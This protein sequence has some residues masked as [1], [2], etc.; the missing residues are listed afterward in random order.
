MSTA[1][2]EVQSSLSNL[3]DDCSL[4]E[5]GEEESEAREH[6]E[7]VT[8]AATLNNPY[9]YRYENRPFFCAEV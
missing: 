3:P 1:K 6:Y 8:V 9:A 5:R 4:E 7:S 2:E